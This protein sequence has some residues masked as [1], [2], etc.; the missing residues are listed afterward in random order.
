MI[1]K[2]KI[3][4]ILN[5]RKNHNKYSIIY[6]SEEFVVI[7]ADTHSKRKLLLIQQPS[8]EIYK[9]IEDGII[10]VENTEA[11][12][13]DEKSLTENGKKQYQRNLKIIK[14][15]EREYG[16]TYLGLM[17]KKKKPVIDKLCEEYNF[18]RQSIWRIIIRYLQSGC[19][20]SS[21]VETRGRTKGGHNKANSLLPGRAPEYGKRTAC[22][23]TE[24]DYQNMDD[25]IDLL[26][27]SNTHA[28][29]KKSVYIEM[30]S[31]HYTVIK[32]Y[33]DGSIRKELLPEGEYPN[34]RQFYTY[35][36]KKITPADY[37]I[38][39]T[40]KREYRNNHRPIIGTERAGLS[41]PGE[42]CDIDATPTDIYLVSKDEPDKLVNR[43]HMY[44]IIDV[45]TGIIISGSVSFEDNSNA[46]V[47]SAMINMKREGR[48]KLLKQCRYTLSNDDIWPTDI[49]PGTLRADRGSEFKAD[50]FKRKCNELGINGQLVTAAT[51]S[52]KGSVEKEFHQFN[53]AMADKFEHKGL[54]LKRY[55]SDHKKTACLNIDDMRKIMISYIIYHNSKVIENRPLSKEMIDRGIN[56]SPVELWKY[57]SEKNPPHLISMSVNQYIWVLMTPAKASMVRQGIRFS[58][59]YYFC[60]QDNYLVKFMRNDQ[61]TQ[62]MEIRYDAAC[63]GHIYYVR[64]GVMFE[65]S[66]NPLY[67][68][69]MSFADMSYKM[70]KEYM[71]KSKALKNQGLH[72]NIQRRIEQ[73]QRLE[74]IRNERENNPVP[75]STDKIRENTKIEKELD[76]RRNK[77]SDLLDADKSNN[78][79]ET[80][81][82]SNAKVL[83]NLSDSNSGNDVNAENKNDS[84]TEKDESNKYAIDE[85]DEE[86]FKE[87]FFE[88]YG[89]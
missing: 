1:Q 8:S 89:Y 9:L 64:D 45:L 53:L 20:L 37:Q 4:Y 10:I 73:N 60:A 49:L 22:V 34:L 70:F 50:E 82:T 55:D 67:P 29:T 62:K 39:K 46:A 75:E 6:V 41:Y 58:G 71:R 12:I 27:H 77:I 32:T 72:D 79:L 23:L 25:A 13:V 65:A 87:K 83:E 26:L 51:G 33:P 69:Q 57:Y 30:L 40:S 11:P 24:K 54:I 19:Q 76:N 15:I 74:M 31:R 81:N 56:S 52:L 14:E 43:G 88:K 85:H 7:C 18:S 44:L 42:L 78:L 36:N 5:D 59:L 47:T 84:S 38:A 2:L 28:F 48:D 86:K 35:V 63:M 80:T 21:L 68:E 17:G 61:K 66:L 3:G 16:P